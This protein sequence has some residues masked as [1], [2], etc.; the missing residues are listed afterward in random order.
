MRS[1]AREPGQT[2]SREERTMA[3]FREFLIPLSLIL[4][5]ILVYLLVI[6][7]LGAGS[8]AAALVGVLAFSG[9]LMVVLP[10]GGDVSEIAAKAGGAEI[11]V[12]LEKIR[13]DVYAKADSV[14]DMTEA[15]AEMTVFSMSR[16]GRLASDDLDRML[17]TFRDRMQDT[18]RKIGSSEPRITEITSK[19]TDVVVFD[20]ANEV[21]RAVQKAMP[22][23]QPGLPPL[24]QVG[25]E[26]IR[27][28]RASPVGEAAT[29]VRPYLDGIKGWNPDVEKRVVEFDEFR[30]SGRLPESK[31][32]GMGVLQ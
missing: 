26:V 14:R 17:L 19:L 23:D 29:A 3:D 13:A 27:L 16:V 2:P 31:R 11:L 7:R 20:L 1:E 22:R 15:I 24:A 6:G 10:R 4:I 18:L 9:V 32:G 12:K 25:S 21:W 5:A 30:R 28:L 8:F